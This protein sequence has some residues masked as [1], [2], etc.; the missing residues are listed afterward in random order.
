M[1]YS[2]RHDRRGT[3]AMGWFLRHGHMVFIRK[4]PQLWLDMYI[5]VTELIRLWRLRMDP[6]GCL[7]TFLWFYL[8]HCDS[9][10]QWND[11]GKFHV[12]RLE[13]VLFHYWSGFRVQRN[14]LF[15]LTVSNFCE[16][17]L[18]L[19]AANDVQ[20]LRRGLPWCGPWTVVSK[21]IP[22]QIRTAPP[23]SSS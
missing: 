20:V 9:I 13:K 4:F 11:C 12:M 23:W 17:Y 1:A 10:A 7:N 19:V 8:R 22:S 15:L 5:L 14:S 3:H 21:R 2:L 18:Y 6:L 16:S